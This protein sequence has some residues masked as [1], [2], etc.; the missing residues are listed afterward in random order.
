M[1]ALTHERSHARQQSKE[2]FVL[3]HAGLNVTKFWSCR[4]I[5]VCKLLDHRDARRSCTALP[6]LFSWSPLCL[7]G[8]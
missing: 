3:I 6:D 4:K 7:A 8:L 5:L 1:I 2:L